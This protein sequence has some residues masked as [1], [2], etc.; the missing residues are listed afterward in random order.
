M[1]NEC[2]YKFLYMLVLDLNKL[3][4]NKKF[5]K[6]QIGWKRFSL[7]SGDSFWNVFEKE[8]IKYLS[9]NEDELKKER[10]LANKLLFQSGNSTT[11]KK[12]SSISN[13][14]PQAK[15]QNEIKQDTKLNHELPSAKIEEPQ[16]DLNKVKI[17]GQDESY[18]LEEVPMDISNN[19]DKPGTSN[20]QGQ[21]EQVNSELKISPEESQPEN[22]PTNNEVEKTDDLDNL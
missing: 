3:G 17:E 6:I 12:S 14:I 16:S 21:P 15:T 22:L 13:N 20:D 19:E 11:R 2:F 1:A 8:R 4:K 18:N 9:E 7:N 10:I 5:L